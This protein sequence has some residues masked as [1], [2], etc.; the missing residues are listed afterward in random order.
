ML[1]ARAASGCGLMEDPRLEAILV[2]EHR[3]VFAALWC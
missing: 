2:D 1:I 3:R